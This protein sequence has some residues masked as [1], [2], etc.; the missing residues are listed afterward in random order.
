MQW[1]SMEVLRGLKIAID[2]ERH[3]EL[4]VLTKK[5]IP[6]EFTAA[7]VVTRENHTSSRKW[8]IM[9]KIRIREI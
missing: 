1:Q 7:E 3:W 2:I 5:V 6:K 4:K 9:A 8:R